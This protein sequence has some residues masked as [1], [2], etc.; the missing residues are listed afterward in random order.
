MATLN[1]T[2][3]EAL[4]FHKNPRPG[5]LATAIAKPLNTQRD[6]SLAYSPGVAYPCKKIAISKDRVYDYTNKG[7]LVAMI[8]NGSAVLGLGNIGAEASKPVMEG[9][10]ILLKKLADID[11]FDIEIDSEDANRIIDVVQAISPTFGAINLEDIKAPDC[12]VIEDAL[13]DTLDIPIMHDDQHGTAIVS[14]AALLNALEIVNKR[15]E[16]IVVVI[17]GAGAAAI[18]CVKLY[19][20]LG[21]KKENIVICDTKGVIRNDRSDLNAYK[22]QFSTSH[23]LHSLQDAMRGADVF[24]GLS[25]AD[26]LSIDDIKT[27]A[28]KP[29]VFAMANP[30]PE[31]NYDLAIGSRKDLIVATGRSDYPNQVNNVLGFPY[32][33]RGAL[34]VR[35]SKI[36]EEMKLAAV[37]AIAD[38]AKM[39]VSR[40]VKETYRSPNLEFGAEYILPKMIDERLLINVSVAVAKAA[41]SSGV[42]RNPIEDWTSYEKSLRGRVAVALT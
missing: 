14:A 33:F 34:D 2:E 19:M 30:N 15:I 7:N 1:I 17:N 13:R 5:S 4:Q 21:L 12:F 8:S 28:P 25:V 39:P 18:A 10:A 26:V 29:I 24:L 41:I 22:A 32:I 20:L 36:N 35:A 16:D 11:C 42:S 37:H 27:M 31:I 9:K 23:N 3:E 6:F 40:H 38:I